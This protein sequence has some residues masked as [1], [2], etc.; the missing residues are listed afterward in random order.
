M[1]I[2]TILLTKGSKE[3]EYDFAETVGYIGFTRLGH[4]WPPFI[5]TDVINLN[6]LLYQIDIITPV[7]FLGLRIRFLKKGVKD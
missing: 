7:I 3:L 1:A 2:G 4:L 6:T 5:K